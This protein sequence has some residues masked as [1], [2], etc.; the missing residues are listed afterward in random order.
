MPKSSKPRR[1]R[2]GSTVRSAR[3][4]AQDPRNLAPRMDAV[5]HDPRA[6]NA[7]RTPDRGDGRPPRFPGRTGGR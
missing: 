7:R 2:G 6:H 1:L 3:T 4:D 5:A